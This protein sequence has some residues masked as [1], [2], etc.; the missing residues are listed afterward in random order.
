MILIVYIQIKVLYKFLTAPASSFLSNDFNT[1][2]NKDFPLP[3]FPTIAFKPG[4]KSISTL[5]PFRL[6]W[7][8]SI[9]ESGIV[10]V[11]D[12]LCWILESGS[13][14]ASSKDSN[15]LLISPKMKLLILLKYGSALCQSEKEK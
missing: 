12:V 7:S 11:L 10:I 1:E 3:L 13:N 8:F 14:V 9:I 2:T 5:E 4:E 15:G 6:K